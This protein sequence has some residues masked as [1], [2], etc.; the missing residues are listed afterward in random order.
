M[1]SAFVARYDSDDMNS[2]K[3]CKTTLLF[4]EPNPERGEIRTGGESEFNWKHVQ[5]P[6]PHCGFTHNFD[7]IE[8]TE[9]FIP[10]SLNPDGTAQAEVYD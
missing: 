6:C 3:S 8:W 4:G 1:K 5:L 7:R 10:T 2:R 9:D